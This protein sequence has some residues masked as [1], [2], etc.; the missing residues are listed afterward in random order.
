[1][2]AWGGGLYDSDFALDLK[3]AIKGI[4]RAP[5]SDDEILA[6]IGTP[7]PSGPDD[8]EALD[9]W[10][11]LADQLERAGMP[12]RAIF[13][14]A[15][16]IIE[17]GEDL[18]AL[19]AL[20]SGKAVLARRRKVHADL[21]ERLRNPRPAKQR[22]P[23]TRPQPLL[24][25]E[26][27]ALAWPTD[28]GACINPYVAEDKL[29][30]LGGFK[31]D[32]WGFG[33]VTAVGHHYGVLAWHSVQAL[34]WRRPERPT[35]ELAARC[36]RSEHHYGTMEPLHFS[37]LKVERLG[38]L[39]PVALGP[40]QD[41]ELARRSSRKAALEDIG[42]SKA[43]G[44][45]AFDHSVWPGPKFMF[46]APSPEPLDPDEPDQRAGMYEEQDEFGPLPPDRPLTRA[47]YFEVMRAR[48]GVQ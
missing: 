20:E 1:M 35:P 2:G 3:S 39:P 9:H 46:S 17:A 10:L 11:V 37:R 42:L 41:P 47:H 16:A 7:T 32:G 4:W 36:P 24:F 38:T 31:Q 43:F 23:L 14:R 33:I 6:E 18:A 25:E 44:W 26:N 48:A 21:L 29:H 13:D 15:V 8:I 22:R 12:R 28:K 27:D 5:L 34:K 40:A 30:L 45:D 19:E